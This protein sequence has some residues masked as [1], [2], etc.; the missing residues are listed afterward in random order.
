MREEGAG[1]RRGRGQGSLW[2]ENSGSLRL[3]S[4]GAAG[5]KEGGASDLLALGHRQPPP[6]PTPSSRDG[7]S[8]SLHK[9]PG[10]GLVWFLRN[11]QTPAQTNS[12][13]REGFWGTARLPPNRLS[14]GDSPARQTRVPPPPRRRRQESERGRGGETTG[15]GRT[16]RRSL[17]SRTGKWSHGLFLL[18]SPPFLPPLP[19]L[20]LLPPP[21]SPRRLLLQGPTTQPPGFRGPSACSAVL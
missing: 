3:G 17:S 20:P 9:Q 21:P 11:P 13:A 16:F 2:C 8:S 10:S 15:R 19:I 4:S 14:P 6:R 18:P 1:V 7:T 5:D 12:Q